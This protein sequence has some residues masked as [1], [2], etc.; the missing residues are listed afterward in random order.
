MVLRASIGARGRRASR[1][2][3]RAGEGDSPVACRL[4]RVALASHESGS[5]GIESQVGGILLLSLNIN[6]RPIAKK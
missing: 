3:R 6:R 1:L 4:P 5:L 2:E